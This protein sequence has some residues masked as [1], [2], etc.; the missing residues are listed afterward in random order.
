MKRIYTIIAVSMALMSQTLTAQDS[1]AKSPNA[2]RPVEGGT[3]V[4]AA[5][6]VVI[7]FAKDKSIVLRMSDGQTKHFKFAAKPVYVAPDG[8]AIEAPSVKPG[9]RVLVHTMEEGNETLI[10]RLFIQN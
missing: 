2:P 9:T 10:D 3:P 4:P 1:H 7:S 5:P 6:A 8:N